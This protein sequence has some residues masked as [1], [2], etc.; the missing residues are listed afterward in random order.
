[1]CSKLEKFVQYKGKPWE[2]LAQLKADKVF[3]GHA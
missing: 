1:M 3:Y 2:M